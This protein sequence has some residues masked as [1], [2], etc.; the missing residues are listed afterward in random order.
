MNAEFSPL[1][2][3]LE[4]LEYPRRKSDRPRAPGTLIN[5]ANTKFSPT[6]GKTNPALELRRHVNI[7]SNISHVAHKG[8]LNSRV[9]QCPSEDQPKVAI[10]MLAPGNIESNVE[11]FRLRKIFALRVDVF[12]Q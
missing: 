9:T 12:H 7:G 11:F 4:T 5:Y 2:E 6:R 1:I 8:G 10:P 3:K